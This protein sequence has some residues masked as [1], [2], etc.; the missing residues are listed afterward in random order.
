MPTVAVVD[1]ILILVYRNDHAPPHVHVR[2][3]GGKGRF[4]IA[5]GRFMDGRL[6]RRT[7]LKV[8]EWIGSN[9]DL[10]TQAWEQ[11]QVTGVP[12]TTASLP[13]ASSGPT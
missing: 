4:E 3:A 11:N 9:Q 6:A 2:H 12:E 8:Q 10:L 5:T 1:G 7:V 13:P